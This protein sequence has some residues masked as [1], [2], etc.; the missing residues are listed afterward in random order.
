M[1]LKKIA[2]A[3][4]AVAMTASMM[5]VPAFAA[6]TNGED[7]DTVTNN[8]TLTNRSA[9]TD[10]KVIYSETSTQISATVPLYVTFAIKN[11]RTFIYPTADYEIKNNSV[12][13]IYVD[14]IKVKMK[15]DKTELT[16]TIDTSAEKQQVKLAMQPGNGDK[17]QLKATDN[18]DGDVQSITKSAWQMDAKDGTN[19]NLKI[20]FSDGEVNKVDTSWIKALNTQDHGTTLFTVVYTIKAGEAQ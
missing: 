14:E 6:G 15:D 5:A 4:L 8:G 19:A 11:D 2:A 20:T 17:L 3:A 10:V 12:V 1:R 9:S 13:P 7:V 16:D 18:T